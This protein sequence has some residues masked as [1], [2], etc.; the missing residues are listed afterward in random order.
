M[1]TNTPILDKSSLYV[2]GLDITWLSTG[3]FQIGAGAVRDSTNTNDMILSSPYVVGLGTKGV[4]GLDSGALTPSTWYAIYI[5]GD[6]TKNTRSKAVISLNSTLPA[7]PGG[8]DMYRRI[9][10]CRTDTGA[11]GT[12]GLIKTYVIGVSRTR[13]YAY[14]VP[15]PALINGN[16]TAVTAVDISASVPNVSPNGTLVNFDATYLPVAA[17]NV[18]LLTIANTATYSNRVGS[19][20]AAAQVTNIQAPIVG[21]TV[22]YK[23]SASGDSF[24]LVTLGFFD[25][26]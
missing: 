14:D 17:G 23:V 21:Q 11:G 9:G 8:F 24:N 16:A 25:Y 5:V 7:S 12:I 18:A 3:T 10:W 2:D 1:A 15:V 22:R 13:Y 4:G 6:S 26:I 19:G 20:V